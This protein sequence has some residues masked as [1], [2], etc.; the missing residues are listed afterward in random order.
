MLV[1]G[2]SQRAAKRTAMERN[3]ISSTGMKKSP[4]QISFGFADHLRK[5]SGSDEDRL[6]GRFVG[7]L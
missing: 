6:M 2:P 1:T 7:H 5:S 4:S 3:E